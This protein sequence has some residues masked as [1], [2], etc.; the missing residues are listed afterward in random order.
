MR[1]QGRIDALGHAPVRLKPGES[2]TVDFGYERSPLGAL[3]AWGEAHAIDFS[4]HLSDDGVNFREVGRISTGDGGSDSFWWRSTK[5]PLF[6]SDGACRRA[7]LRARSL[8][9]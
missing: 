2:I 6:P 4:A 3:I 7:R 8:A 5:A 9:N 1:E